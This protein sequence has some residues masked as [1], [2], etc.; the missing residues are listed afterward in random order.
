LVN[1]CS[2]FGPNLWRGGLPPF[3]RAAVAKQG[4]TVFQT[5][6]VAWIWDYFVVQRGQAPSPQDA[7]QG[8]QSHMFQAWHGRQANFPTG[9]QGPFFYACRIK[10]EHRIPLVGAS[11]LAINRRTPRGVRLSALSLTT[12]ASRLAPTGYC[13]SSR[14]WPRPK[15]WRCSW[16][17]RW[18]RSMSWS[19]TWSTIWRAVHAMFCWVFQIL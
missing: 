1:E 15:S 19:I 9:P 5:F 3:G 17:R 16:S 11:L 18:P 14:H 4:C 6:R 12:T 2:P 8:Y 13:A 10:I 7:A